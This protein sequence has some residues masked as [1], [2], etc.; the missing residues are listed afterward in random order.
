MLAAVWSSRPWISSSSM[1]NSS[2]LRG[3]VPGGDTKHFDVLSS[4]QVTSKVY[5]VCSCVAGGVQ[6]CNLPWGYFPV[7]FASV[8][9]GLA[10]VVFVEL[11]SELHEGSVVGLSNCDCAQKS[12]SECFMHLW[13][14]FFNLI[15]FSEVC[16]KILFN[17]SLLPNLFSWSRQQP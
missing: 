13:F 4:I 16:L 1:G 11:S 7:R 5:L 15:G 8:H 14:F 9:F 12:E 10:S 3:P 17:W 6:S 2:S